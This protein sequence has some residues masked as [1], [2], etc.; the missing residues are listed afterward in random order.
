[1]IVVVLIQIYHSFY[2]DSARLDDDITVANW[3]QYDTAAYNRWVIHWKQ[4]LG[5]PLESFLVDSN[6]LKNILE[7][8]KTINALPNKHH[9]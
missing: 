9:F 1:M 8:R 3:P 7:K 4:S 6:S 2:H 5:L